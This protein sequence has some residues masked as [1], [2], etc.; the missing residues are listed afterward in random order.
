MAIDFAKAKNMLG[1]ASAE[2]II[3]FDIGLWAIMMST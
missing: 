3:Y 1:C 2:V